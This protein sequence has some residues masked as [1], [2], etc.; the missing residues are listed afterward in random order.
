MPQNGRYSISKTT[1]A[2]KPY[3]PAS[4]PT[5]IITHDDILADHRG[6]KNL[7]VLMPPRQPN[8]QLAAADE[9]AG[10]HGKNQPVGAR[11]DV[12]GV[13]KNDRR[14]GD[15]DEQSGKRESA[16]NGVGMKLRM[17]DDGRRSP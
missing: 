9:A 2:A 1:F 7:S 16:A 13:D 5:R 3:Q 10:E 12:E 17:L 6:A 11:T 8:V 15:I 14:A 4:V